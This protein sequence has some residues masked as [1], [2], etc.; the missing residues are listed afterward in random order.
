[1]TRPR[2]C[3]D[4]GSPSA[5]GPNTLASG[6]SGHANFQTFS[7]ADLAPLISLLSDVSTVSARKM[8]S[9]TAFLGT[10]P[11]LLGEVPTGL[12]SKSICLRA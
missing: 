12:L 10:K 2:I 1:M 6:L 5:H 8:P 9:C 7:N 11:F 4:E 3:K